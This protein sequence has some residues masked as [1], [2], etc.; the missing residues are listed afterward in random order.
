MHN[1]ALEVICVK[2]YI[3]T[4]DIIYA[5]YVR[6]HQFNYI[7]LFCY[8]TN[9]IF[10]YVR[11]STIHKRTL[12]IFFCINTIVS[13]LVVEAKTICIRMFLAKYINT[14]KFIYYFLA[15]RQTQS[16]FLFFVVVVVFLLIFLHNYIFLVVSFD[17]SYCKMFNERHMYL[18]LILLLLLLSLLYILYIFFFLFRTHAGET[19]NIYL[20]YFCLNLFYFFFSAFLFLFFCT[21]SPFFIFQFF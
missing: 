16:V 6:M 9:I 5:D 8:C 18:I 10:P 17:S 12:Q 2:T 19:L 4:F 15:V 1:K 3:C 21:T 11:V 14:Y 20:Y 13:A 7:Q